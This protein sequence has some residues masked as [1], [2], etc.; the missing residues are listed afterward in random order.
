MKRRSRGG[1][2]PFNHLTVLLPAFRI[3]KGTHP[4]LNA[5]D[6]SESHTGI[7]IEVEGSSMDVARRWTPEVVEW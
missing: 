4:H 6:D 2:G 3:G 5:F 7:G 1:C